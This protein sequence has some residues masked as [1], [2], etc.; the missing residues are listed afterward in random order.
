MRAD[1]I[2]IG[3]GTGGAK[4]TV[5]RALAA[6]H[7]LRLFAIDAFWYAHE[8]RLAEPRLSPDD[9]WLGLTPSQQAD[10]FEASAQRRFALVQSDLAGLPLRPSIVVEGPQVRPE[11]LWPG[12][13]AIFLIPSPAFQRSNL[14]RRPMPPTGDPAR[15]LANR[16]EKDRLYAERIR[17]GAAACGFPVVDVDGS[18]TPGQLVN[19]V[20]RLA[21]PV[22]AD[23]RPP[24]DL[25]GVRRWQNEVVADNIA[26]WL[27]SADVPAGSGVLQ[28]FDCECG[29]PGCAEQV[30]LTL[31]QYR[32]TRRVVAPGHG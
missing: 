25:T 17:I 5:A 6:R 16:V 4:T 1:V 8:P 11:M 20:Q 31:N 15:A 21:A 13:A 3:G 29:R 2:W 23:H 18:L 10:W 14:L 12:A 7:G 32:A 28:P 30:S 24:A 22:L 19:A 9:Q 27:A 26:R